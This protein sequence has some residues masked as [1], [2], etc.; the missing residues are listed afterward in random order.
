MQGCQVFWRDFLF[1]LGSKIQRIIPSQSWIGSTGSPHM[2][3]VGTV[4][5]LFS[6][7]LSRHT[8][9]LVAMTHLPRESQQ[10][11]LRFAF[12]DLTKE[13]CS[14]IETDG[15]LFILWSV[16]YYPAS[17]AWDF[18]CRYPGNMSMNLFP[19][20]SALIDWSSSSST[21]IRMRLWHPTFVWRRVV[22]ARDKS[23]PSWHVLDGLEAPAGKS[24]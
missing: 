18:C 6:C 1:R 9:I 16:G 13:L 17:H 24:S 12:S 20:R 2:V 10:V 14:R 22:R 3:E 7:N 5:A 23:V 19:S 8:T 4:S 11:L 21:S 15:G